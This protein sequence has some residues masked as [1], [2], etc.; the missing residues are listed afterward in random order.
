MFKYF[1]SYMIVGNSIG[2]DSSSDT[3]SL[4]HFTLY[5]NI[6]IIVNQVDNID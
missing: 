4:M 1:I 2:C 3:K 5:L 6:D